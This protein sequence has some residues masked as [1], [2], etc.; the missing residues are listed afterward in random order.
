MTN[1]HEIYKCNICGNITEVLHTGAG[2]L[3]CCGQPMQLLTPNTVDAALEKH[4][5]VITQTP[6]GTLIQVGSTPHPM[7]P[8]HHIEWIEATCSSGKRVRKHLQPG[9]EPT[10]LLKNSSA[11]TVQARAYCNLH[12]LWA[13]A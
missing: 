9:D 12:G 1:L 4:V 8:E 5:P 2:E 10:L 7:T 13:S 6:D 3:V 11:S